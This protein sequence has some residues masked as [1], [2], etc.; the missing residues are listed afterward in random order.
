[1]PTPKAP[2]TFVLQWHLTARCQQNCLHCYMKDEPTYA[3]ELKNELET[4]VCFRIIDS[5]V[6]DFSPLCKGLR[7]NFTGGDPLLKKGIF[8]LINY[9]AKKGI[10]V[11]ILG[12]PNLVTP[13]T[14]KKLKKAG[15]K[16]IK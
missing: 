8:E 14:A 7:I 15:L 13:Q 10:W 11:G 1:M 12:N 3:S 5:F 2:L 4:E 6:K 16:V 9:A